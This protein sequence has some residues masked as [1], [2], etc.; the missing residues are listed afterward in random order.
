MGLLQINS[1]RSRS[2]FLVFVLIGGVSLQAFV[3]R[4]RRVS[5]ASLLSSLTSTTKRKRNLNGREA[6]GSDST[7]ASAFDDLHLNE[8]CY[9]A[10]F[11][12]RRGPLFGTF[13]CICQ[14][15][16]LDSM[17]NGKIKHLKKFPYSELKEALLNFSK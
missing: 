6:A 1:V 4:H 9:S 16:I 5:P 11:L 2:F 8:T 14:S 7:S 15:K 12:L 13:N 17:M 3:V 10:N